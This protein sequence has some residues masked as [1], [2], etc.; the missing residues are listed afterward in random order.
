MAGFPPPVPDHD[1][2]DDVQ[3]IASQANLRRPEANVRVPDDTASGARQAVKDFAARIWDEWPG[4][5]A[6]GGGLVLISFAAPIGER[7]ALLR[8]RVKDFRWLI[9]FLSSS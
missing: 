2:A 3:P 6:P 5:E 7:R 9:S 4:M 1:A 8:W